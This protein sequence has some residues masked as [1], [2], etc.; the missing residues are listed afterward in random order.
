MQSIRSELELESETDLQIV[1]ISE[2]DDYVEYCMLLSQLTT[3][4]VQNINQETFRHRLKLIKSNPFHKIFV[5]KIQNKII[6][7]ATIL[8]EPKII[9]DLSF[10]AHIEDVVV[11]SN[12]RS[13]GIGKKL[14][15]KLIEIGKQANCYKIILDCN[16]Y[17]IGFYQKL[18][19]VVKE[20]QMVNYNI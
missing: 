10:V 2:L 19:F 8:I 18:G 11:D 15:N 5:A 6:G 13:E 1:E 4:N 14:M 3:L 7:T 17:N 16:N 20:N 9:H 12:Y